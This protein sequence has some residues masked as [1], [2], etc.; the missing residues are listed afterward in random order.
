[1]LKTELEVETIGEPSVQALPEAEQRS[2][3]ET[4]LARIKELKKIKTI[5]EEKFMPYREAKVYFDGGHYIAIPS[6]NFPSKNRKGQKPKPKPTP[7]Q[8]ADGTPP[9]F[10]TCIKKRTRKLVVARWR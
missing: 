5:K 6:E 3:F 7:E 1:M 8:Q 4:L 10:S 9:T 2:F